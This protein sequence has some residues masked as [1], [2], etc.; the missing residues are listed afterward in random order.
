MAMKED[1]LLKIALLTSVIGL[2]LLLFVSENIEIGNYSQFT[3]EVGSD[4]KLDGY[5]QKISSREGVTFITVNYSSPV[6][7][8]L[9]TKEDVSLNENDYVQ[10]TGKI[11]KF[12][13]EKEIIASNVRVIR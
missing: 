2:V 5:I 11:D 6:Q 4:V 1:L 10:V 8:I 9:F 12:Q 7:I 13:G 3:G